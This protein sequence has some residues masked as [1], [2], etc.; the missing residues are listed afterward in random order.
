MFPFVND[1]RPV[2]DTKNKNIGKE[3]TLINGCKTLK[4][5]KTIHRYACECISLPTKEKIVQK[6]NIIYF[7]SDAHLGI[8]DYQSSL[9]R[10]KLLI[11]FLDKASQDASEIFLLGDIF[12]FWFEYKSVVPKGFVR[13]LGKIAGITDSGI[14]VHYFTGNHDMW[15]FDYFTK[16]LGVIMHRKPLEKEVNGKLFY[17]AHGDGL[18]P[19]DYGYKFLKSVFSSPVSKKLFSWLHPGF[20]TS[21]AL[22]FSRKSRL[23]NGSKDEIFLGEK[24]E[25]L[26]NFC[27]ELVKHKP[28]NYFLF[29]HR[30]LPMDITISGTARY[31]NTGEWVKSFSYAVFDGEDLHLKYFRKDKNTPLSQ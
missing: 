3:L 13:L 6:K 8:P 29:G 24:N 23:A 15:I 22:Y 18:G 12:D 11:E 1:I 21:L 19:G 2:K 7:V 26:I 25:R 17:I 28:Y 20:G 4:A 31:I 10:E 5:S 14:P 27:R 16:E 30:H 9:K